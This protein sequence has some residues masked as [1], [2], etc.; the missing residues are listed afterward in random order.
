MTD[1]KTRGLHSLSHHC[2]KKRTRSR[3]RF[4]F[5]WNS[6]DGIELNKAAQIILVVHHEAPFWGG[7]SRLHNCSFVV[8][9]S[10]S[11]HAILFTV[12][13]GY[14][15]TMLHDQP[16]AGCPR[17]RN[18][19]RQHLFGE[20][21][22]CGIRRIPAATLRYRPFAASCQV[23]VHSDPHRC[24]LLRFDW[25]LEITRNIWRSSHRR[26]NWGTWIFGLNCT[27]MQSTLPCAC[28]FPPLKS[29]CESLFIFSFGGP[30]LIE[31]LGCQASWW[32]RQT[33]QNYYRIERILR[34]DGSNHFLSG[35]SISET[36]HGRTEWLYR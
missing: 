23:L 21:W 1:L 13:K 14:P 35:G 8:L 12:P 28:R 11:V 2:E 29:T 18:P 16:T 34:Q 4:I 17:H 25:R 9:A 20:G 15:P 31:T 6:F 32:S 10:A 5:A 7:T 3:S 33:D 24:Q 26:G 36:I 19:N 27:R 22:E 30:L